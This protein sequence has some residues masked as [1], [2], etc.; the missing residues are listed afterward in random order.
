MKDYKAI[1]NNNRDSEKQLEKIKQDS[2]M[3][4]ERN[5][6]K[7]KAELLE[8]RK[9]SIYTTVVD[10]ENFQDALKIMFD[11]SMH[12]QRM[13]KENTVTTA[14]MLDHAT[15]SVNAKRR[16]FFASKNAFALTNDNLL[17]SINMV[18][19]EDDIVCYDPNLDGYTYATIKIDPNDE[20]SETVMVFANDLTQEKD[21]HLTRLEAH[22]TQA[23]ASAK[24]VLADAILEKRQYVKSTSSL[25]KMLHPFI[26]QSNLTFF[27]TKIITAQSCVDQFVKE[28]ENIKK[29]KQYISQRKVRQYEDSLLQCLNRGNSLQ[30][31][32][33]K[34]AELERLLKKYTAP[35][36]IVPFDI[37]LETPEVNPIECEEKMRK[38][39]KYLNANNINLRYNDGSQGFDISQFVEFKAFKYEMLAFLEFL[40]KHPAFAQISGLSSDLSDNDDSTL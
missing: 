10:L 39:V 9:K 3:I 16:L 32:K 21:S 13:A 14:Q 37:F 40:D 15:I 26:H 36:M 19:N 8:D 33:I 11:Y 2:A 30:I 24:L 7:K 1:F 28:L 22:Y 35:E 27:E 38:L 17:A 25:D 31:A 18:N 34:K 20:Q 6:K 29:A 23:L 12:N 4:K 5:E